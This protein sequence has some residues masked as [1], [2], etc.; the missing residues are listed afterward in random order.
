MKGDLARVLDTLERPA[1]VEV[2]LSIAIGK[3]YATSIARHL[4]KKQ[5]TV[6]EQLARLESLG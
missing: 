2:L 1:Y 6:T 4:G 5:P 3:N